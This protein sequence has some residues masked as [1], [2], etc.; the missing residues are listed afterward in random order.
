MQSSVARYINKRLTSSV[1]VSQEA[2]K[3]GR[4][5]DAKVLSNK[6]KAEAALMEKANRMASKSAFQTN[7]KGRDS[8]TVDL[9]GLFVEE[10][11]QRARECIAKARS[12]VNCW[13]RSPDIRPTMLASCWNQDACT[14][15]CLT[16]SAECRMHKSLQIRHSGSLDLTSC[17]LQQIVEAVYG[18]RGVVD[19][20]YIY[21][22]IYTGLGCYSQLP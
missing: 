17:S 2:Y 14:W 5:A 8:A 11:V 19:V 13:H 6:G 12:E 20:I 1:Q 22:Y 4:G 9:H 10:A 18:H 15:H 16:F 3:E 7:N 21:I